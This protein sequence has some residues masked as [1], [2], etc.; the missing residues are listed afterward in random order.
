[1]VEHEFEGMGHRTML[2]NAHT[3]SSTPDAEPMILLA[4]EDITERSQTEAALRESEEK[5]RT[6]FESIDEG[7]CIIEEVE[8]GTD[9]LLDF[10]YVAANPAFKTQSGSAAWSGKPS[11]R[12]FRANQRSGSK[13]MM[14]LSKLAIRSD[15]NAICRTEHSLSASGRRKLSTSK[16]WQTS[17]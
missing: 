11:G 17:H 10:R 3:L 1:M 7:F 9:G 8:G 2:L 15:L 16:R 12:R 14:R 4:I 5:Y 13:P 6:L